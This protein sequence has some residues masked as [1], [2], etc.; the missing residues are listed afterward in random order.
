LV[1][2]LDVINSPCRRYDAFWERALSLEEEIEGDWKGQRP[3]QNLE[4]IG[5]KLYGMMDT[6]HSWSKK[7]KQSGLSQGN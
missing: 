5:S 4:D 7:K 1:C 3:A 2:A 6:L